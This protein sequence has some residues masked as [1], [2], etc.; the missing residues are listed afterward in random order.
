MLHLNPFC[1]WF[2]TLLMQSCLNEC[3]YW[4]VRISETINSLVLNSWWQA[5][6]DGVENYL[7]GCIAFN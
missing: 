1:P 7:V 4:V 2:F 3:F 5:R 6:A